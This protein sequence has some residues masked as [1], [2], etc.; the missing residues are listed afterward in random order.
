M[1]LMEM[2][3]TENKNNKKGSNMSKPLPQTTT[4]I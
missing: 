3:E 2:L 1:A 4:H